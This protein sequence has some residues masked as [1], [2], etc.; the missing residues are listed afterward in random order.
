MLLRSYVVNTLVDAAIV[1][2]NN[3]GL[4]SPDSPDIRGDKLRMS[5]SRPRLDWRDS[6]GAAGGTCSK[7][8]H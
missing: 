3:I 7:E 8:L 6:V 2:P 1:W 5:P 4:G